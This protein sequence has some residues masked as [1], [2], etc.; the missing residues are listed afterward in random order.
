M[1]SACQVSVGTLY[2]L[3]QKCNISLSFRI[4]LKI[5]L[6]SFSFGT[7]LCV[8]C[9]V[10]SLPKMTENNI[11]TSDSDFKML[12]YA[13]LIMVFHPIQL[14]LNL[15]L[16][17]SSTTP[18]MITPGGCGTWRPKRKSYTRRATARVSMTCTSTQMALWRGQG[19]AHMHTV[20]LCGFTIISHN[21][22]SLG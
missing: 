12:A 14:T 9:L 8:I 3:P 5:V 15:S 18:V 20:L 17:F 7:S 11:L 16:S 21:P 6:F 4:G 19:K 10:L 1:L 13:F 22:L 2:S